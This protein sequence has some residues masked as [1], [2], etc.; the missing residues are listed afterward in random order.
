MTQEPCRRRPPPRRAH[1]ALAALTCTAWLAACGGGSSAA[2]TVPPV[3]T[4]EP[5]DVTVDVGATATFAVQASGTPAPS[6]TWQRQVGGAWVE[7]PGAASATYAFTARAADDGSR[8]RALATSAAG[9]ATSQQAIAHVRFVE[10]VAQPQDQVAVVGGT[11]TFAVVVSSN[12]APT[13]QWQR[14]TDGGASWTDAAGV[15]DQASYATATLAAG[16]DGHRYRVVVGSGA[17]PSV[18]SAAARLTVQA[19]VAITSQPESQV[20]IAPAAATFS[21]GAAGSPAPTYQWQRSNDGGTTWADVTGA[22]ATGYTTA[23]TALGDQGARFRVVASNGIGAA[24]TSDAAALT[25][26]V[27]P[28]ITSQPAS[29]TV[30][31]GGAATFAVVAEGYPAVSYQWQ[32]SDDGSGTWASVAGGSSATAASRAAARGSRP[33]VAPAHCRSSGEVRAES[34]S[35]RRGSASRA[36]QRARRSRAFPCFRVRRERSRSASA[37]GRSAEA[38]SSRSTEEPQSSSTASSRALMAG[39]SVSG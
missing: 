22:T 39:G 18:T 35:P 21:A 34:S 13:F 2:G 3:I 25:V 23:A 17:G 15:A 36:P 30:A 16:D 10:L 38:R 8:F 33:P 12:P 32:R 4:A 19:P 29:A 11:A 24:A 27:A 31:P 28:L 7:I 5:A 26:N 1:A 6:F 14:S 20:V 9:T 37:T